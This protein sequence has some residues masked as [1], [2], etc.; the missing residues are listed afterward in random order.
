MKH[1][2]NIKELTIEP[3]VEPSALA[4]SSLELTTEPKEPTITKTEKNLQQSQQ[5]QKKN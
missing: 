4:R 1:N 2:E 5:L 3:T